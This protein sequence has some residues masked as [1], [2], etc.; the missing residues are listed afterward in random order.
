ME[1]KT[2]VT[3]ELEEYG[4][5]ASVTVSTKG[6]ERKIVIDARTNDDSSRY[7]NEPAPSLHF[8]G[9]PTQLADSVAFLTK[10]LEEAKGHVPT[11]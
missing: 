8:V 6:R 2:T 1:K 9:S 5:K 10:V 11:P 3:T 7:R 4:H